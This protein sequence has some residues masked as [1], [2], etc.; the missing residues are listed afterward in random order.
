LWKTA[1]AAAGIVDH[2]GVV[3]NT[4]E[5]KAPRFTL[6]AADVGVVSSANIAVLT[7]ITT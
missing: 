5:A 3:A 6:V 1:I 7:G 2:R 4:R